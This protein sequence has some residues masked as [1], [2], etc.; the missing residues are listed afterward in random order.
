LKRIMGGRQIKI[1]EGDPVTLKVGVSG[2]TVKAIPKRIELDD[3]LL[4]VTPENLHAAS[5]WGAEIG[6]ES[7]L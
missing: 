3:L 7:Y 1:Q 4:Q 6:H 2:L 5:D